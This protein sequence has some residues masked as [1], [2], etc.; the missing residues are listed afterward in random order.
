V[1]LPRSPAV[2]SRKLTITWV[3]PALPGPF[4]FA[5]SSAPTRVSLPAGNWRSAPS[6]NFRPSAGSASAISSAAASPA[7][8]SG[9]LITRSAQRSQNGARSRLGCVEPGR[10][11]MLRSP[12]TTR[13]ATI[14]GRPRE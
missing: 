10:R 6:P 9:R 4:A 5:A 1:R 14:A 7:E 8:T 2:P 3:G 11:R 12:R 13:P